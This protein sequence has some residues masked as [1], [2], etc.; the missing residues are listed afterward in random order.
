MRCGFERFCIIFVSAFQKKKK[1]LITFGNN[2]Q[3]PHIN[4]HRRSINPVSVVLRYSDTRSWNDHKKHRVTLM[5]VV[6]G[7]YTK[8]KHLDHTG[9]ISTTLHQVSVTSVLS[10]SHLQ[11]LDDTDCACLCF[12]LHHDW[13]MQYRIL[14]SIGQYRK[15]TCTYTRW[16]L[17]TELI[18]FSSMYLIAHFIH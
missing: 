4:K 7:S 14:Y 16:G 17:C 12:S 5:S 18:F 11:Y 13:Y 10:Q 2:E 3:P 6:S 8:P 9:S 15:H 1:Q